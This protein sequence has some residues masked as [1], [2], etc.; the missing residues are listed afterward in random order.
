MS[1]LD[2]AKERLFSSVGLGQKKEITDAQDQP[3]ADQ[4]LAGYIKSK[5]EQSRSM[6]NR[7]AHEGNWMTNIAYL[8]GFDSVYYDTQARQFRPL[9]GSSFLKRNRLSSNQILPACQNRLARLC[10]QPPKYEIL[11]NSNQPDDRDSARLSL[12]VL[13]DLWESQEIN[14]KRLTLGMWTQQ[15]GHAYAKVSYDETL[16]QPLIEDPNQGVKTSFTGDIRVDVVSAFEVF[17]DPIAKSWDEVTWVA[18]C[19]VRNLDYFRLH[20]PEKGQLVKAEGMWLMSMQYEARINSLNSMGPSASGALQENMK[21]SAIE[22]AY[23]EK[24]S[25]LHPNGRMVIVANGVVLKDDELPCGEIP[26]VK[27]DDIIVAGKFYPESVITHCRP[28][29]QQYNRDLSKGAEWV[30]AL[31]AGKWIAEK[32]HGLAK[33]ALND[34]TEVIAYN[35]VPGAAEPHAVTVPQLPSYYFE[36]CQQLKK[37]INEIFGLS[38]VSRGQLPA[39]G[40]PAVGMQLLVEQDET[41]IGIEVE[42]HEYAYA[43]LGQLMLKY[44]NKFVKT[45]RKLKK[46]GKNGEYN[47]RDWSGDDLREHYDV[48]VVRGSTIPTSRSLKR[49]EI[50]NAYQQG[51]LGDLQDPAVR[52]K[53]LGMLEFGSSSEMWEKRSLDMAQISKTLDEIKQGVVPQVNE[54][55]NHR[56]HIEKKNEFRISDKFSQLEKPKQD[57]LLQDIDLHVEMA[58]NLMNPGLNHQIKQTESSLR[59]IDQSLAAEPEMNQNEMMPQAGMEAPPNA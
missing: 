25:S 9:S 37:D 21:N 14:R 52:E 19:K 34:R 13:N 10:K 22:V 45:P 5:V 59:G 53:V 31:L 17:P 11:P 16:G 4:K 46:K 15:C 30:N 57:L 49:Q 6:A 8:L 54:L 56:L 41:R 43:K 47:I 1:F 50:L 48:R 26:L 40:I 24:K 29:Q 18:H 7:V 38:E 28:L 32:R 39:A 2:Q 42:Q 55:D 33:E 36:H 51:L 35:H 12:D 23:Y 27:Y 58:M 3:D 44:A 20:F